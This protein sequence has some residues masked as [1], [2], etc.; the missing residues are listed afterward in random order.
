MS[1]TDFKGDVYIHSTNDGGE[2]GIEDGL[3][4][5]CNTFSTAV[6]LSLFGGNKDDDAGRSKETWWGNLVSGTGENE[7]IVSQFQAAIC[8]L[9]LTSGNLKKA[10]A[11]AERDLAWLKDEGIAD[12][13]SVTLK[14]EDVKRVAVTVEVR[15]DGGKIFESNYY[16]E[17]EGARN[18]LR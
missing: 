10:Q 13:V 18:G 3:V 6:Y 8:G 1:K 4:L 17:W 15:K 12:S 2:I 14:A 16:F 9:P 11:A 5:D 7:R